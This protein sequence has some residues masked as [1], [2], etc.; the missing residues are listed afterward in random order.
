VQTILDTSSLI[1]YLTCALN[2]TQIKEEDQ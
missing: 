1:G 2:Y